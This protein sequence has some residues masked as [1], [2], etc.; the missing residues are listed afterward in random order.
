V[1]S[2]GAAAANARWAVV[3]SNQ[4]ARTWSSPAGRVAA[5]LSS[6]GAA[7]ESHGGRSEQGRGLVDF[8]WCGLPYFVQV[9]DSSMS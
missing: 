5:G 3:D 6:R 4:R 8:Q 7:R 2:Q 1:G 9:G